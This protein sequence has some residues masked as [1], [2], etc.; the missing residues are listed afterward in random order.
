MQSIGA[1]TL[2]QHG[3][4]NDAELA[5][6]GMHLKQLEVGHVFFLRDCL[7]VHTAS[8]T[9]TQTSA[10]SS[11]SLSSLTTT[12]KAALSSQGANDL[13]LEEW[14]RGQGAEHRQDL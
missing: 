3:P 12:N 1:K 13:C 11:F 14:A 9:L 6:A 2:P 4:I 8:H 5:Q 10:P 7:L